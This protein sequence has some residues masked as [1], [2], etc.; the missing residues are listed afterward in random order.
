MADEADQPLESESN[1]Q[2]TRLPFKAILLLVGVGVTLVWSATYP[3]MKITAAEIPILTFRGLIAIGSVL[4][5][6][7]ITIIDLLAFGL[8]AGALLTVLPLPRLW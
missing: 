5:D 6:E 3:V 4:V 7:S 8:I 2:R 1:P